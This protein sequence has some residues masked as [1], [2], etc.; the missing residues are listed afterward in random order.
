VQRYKGNNAGRD[1][2]KDLY[3]KQFRAN[4]GLRR[5]RQPQEVFGTCQ[6]A[7]GQAKPIIAPVAQPLERWNPLTVSP[8]MHGPDTDGAA[9][10]GEEARGRGGAEVKRKRSEAGLSEKLM[11]MPEAKLYTQLVELE[12]KIDAVISRKELEFAEELK[13]PTMTQRTL[14]V[15]LYNTHENQGGDGAGT[16][17]WTLHI[18]GRLLDSTGKGGKEVAFTDLFDRVFVDLPAQDYPGCGTAS[19]ARG[20]AQDGGGGEMGGVVA[21]RQGA[22]SSLKMRREGSKEC[23]VKVQLHPLYTPARYTLKDQPELSKLLGWKRGT[24]ASLLLAFWGYVRGEGLQDEDSSLYVKLDEKMQQI[25]EEG[26]SRMPL[27]QVGER[28]WE[29]VS[30]VDPVELEYTLCL[31]GEA[32][33]AVYEVLVEAE[34]EISEMMREFVDEGVARK[35]ETECATIEGEIADLMI[36]IEAKRRKRDFLNRFAESPAELLDDV[37]YSMS[38]DLATVR[39]TG[40][41]QFSKLTSEEVLRSE[42][43]QQFWTEEAALHYLSIQGHGVCLNL[44]NTLAE[45]VLPPTNTHVHRHGH[46]AQCKR[47]CGR[48]DARVHAHL[49]THICTCVLLCCC[50]FPSTLPRSQTLEIRPFHSILPGASNPRD[51]SQPLMRA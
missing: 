17:S 21:D 36:E 33:P 47:A 4:S 50:C 29:F 7:G 15:Y 49:N 19:W 31:S 37:S 40:L 42:V 38:A 25:F 16:A 20:G 5:Q 48:M 30:E 8:Y 24:W 43:W 12:E 46:A 13:A 51:A 2:S 6:Q 32:T 1:D 39:T 26:A 22:M 9:G 14:Q 11:T 10:E 44:E 35:R 3:A 27:T 28:L 41:S 18:T 34:D 23:K 45:E